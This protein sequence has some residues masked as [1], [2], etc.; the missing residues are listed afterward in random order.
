MEPF[1]LLEPF[2]L[3]AALLV[4][5]IFLYQAGCEDCW[6]VATFVRQNMKS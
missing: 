6:S 3:V 2:H 4:L 5:L 1:H